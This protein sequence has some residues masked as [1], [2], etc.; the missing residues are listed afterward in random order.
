MPAEPITAGAP[1]GTQK[2]TDW[3]EMPAEP[4]EQGAGDGLHKTTDWSK[5]E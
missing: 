1:A 4:I 3:S 5:M 2:T